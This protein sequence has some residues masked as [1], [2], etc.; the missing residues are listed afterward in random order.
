MP[1][2]N[3]FDPNSGSLDR[4]VRAQWRANRRAAYRL[5]YKERE[6]KQ[7]PA[8][9]QAV[10]KKA[11]KALVEQVE[12]PRGMNWNDFGELWDLHPEHPF[13]S[14]L[15]RKSVSDEWAEVTDKFP[16]LPVS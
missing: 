8:T 2:M 15:R 11:E 3:V 7:H 16:E 13:T 1:E 6:G 4:E 5:A 12:L 9:R 14:V 10:N